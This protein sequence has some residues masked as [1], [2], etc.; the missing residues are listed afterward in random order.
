MSGIQTVLSVFGGVGLSAFAVAVACYG[1]FRWLGEKWLSSKFDQRMEDYKHLQVRELESLKLKINSMLDR[2]VKLNKLEFDILPK[3][4]QKLTEAHGEVSRFTSPMQSYPD[5][6]RMGS[7]E[8]EEF[9]KDLDFKD[10]QK[11]EILEASDKNKKYQEIEFWKRLNDANKVYVNF[12]N[13]YITNTIFLAD[14]MKAKIDELRDMMYDAMQE[15][16]F[17]KEYGEPR[18]DR[19][20]KREI[21]RKEG[22]SKVDDVR[23]EFR[24][25]L[26]LWRE[27]LD[28]SSVQHKALEK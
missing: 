11:H 10:Y 19:Y 14:E 26:L 28:V 12:N 13:F 23:E 16:R 22:R 18:K 21:L 27:E 8:R 1:L 5:L 24:K 20:E 6:D 4:W 25:K 7:T 9:V 15:A 2:S 3:I 17:E